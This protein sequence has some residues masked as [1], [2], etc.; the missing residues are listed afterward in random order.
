[1]AT[2]AIPFNYRMPPPGA[3]D[4]NTGQPISGAAPADPNAA[5]TPPSA[6]SGIYGNPQPPAAPQFGPDMGVM[7]NITTGQN[8]AVAGAGQINN[9]ATSQLN[10][11]SPLQQ[12]SQQQ[13]AAALADLNKTPGYTAPEASQI[14][15]DYGKYR[16]SQGDL[17]KQFLNPGEQS[18]I[19]GDPNAPKGTMTAGTAAEGA[20]LNAYGANL[21][22]QVSNLDTNVSGGLT[23]ES[24]NV[25]GAN[26]NLDQGLAGAQ[27]KFGKLDTVVGNKALGF[28]PNSTE[29]QLTDADV[30]QMKTAAGTRVGNQ[31]RAAEDTLQQNAAAAGNTSPLALAAANARLQSQEASGQGDA[32]TN[33]DIAARQ[34]QYSRASGIEGQRYGETANTTGIR[35]GAA[36]TE[37]QAAQNAA[38]LAGTTDVNS[39]LRVGET[40]VQAAEMTGAAGI[41]AANTYGSTAVNQATNAANQNYGA[42]ATA[43]QEAAA[44]A[45]ALATNRQATQGNVNATTYGQGVQTAQ[46]TAAGATA[47]GGARMAGQG[48]Y[49]AGVTQQQGLAQEGG[50]NAIQAQNTALATRTSGITG[51]GS[52][53]TSD[54]GN[55]QRNSIVNQ[56]ATLGSAFLEKGG[57]ITEPTIATVG[58][59]GPEKIVPLG[60]YRS[61]ERKAA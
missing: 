39:A 53:A 1:M 19:A 48:A 34:A 40:G 60:S 25:A 20:Q 5:L 21:G 41:N 12:Q 36:T 32:E 49:R 57:I 2:Q 31:Y 30:Q 28:D 8:A 15:V 52:N 43:E 4:P 44:R 50:Q 11:Y 37:E 59:H 38:A 10:Y 17:N 3:I 51:A 6:P 56:A 9:E 55:N 35:A 46:D 54:Q 24:T 23:N 14:N 47:V 61:R 42:S 45:A 27:D 18:G 26:K 16:T 7:N 58:E 22:G 13:E 29:K 33:A